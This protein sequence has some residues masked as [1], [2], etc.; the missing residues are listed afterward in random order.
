[1]EAAQLQ[2]VWFREARHV[3]DIAA[4]GE[5]IENKDDWYVG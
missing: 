4:S 3:E 5:E 2:K 1:M